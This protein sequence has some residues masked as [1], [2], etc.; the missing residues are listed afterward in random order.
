LAFCEFQDSGI[1]TRRALLF[2][3]IA[4]GE[5]KR[6]KGI[7]KGVATRR[8]IMIYGFGVAPKVIQERGVKRRRCIP[9]TPRKCLG[10]EWV[11][12]MQEER[13]GLM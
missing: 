6:D 4:L 2:E 13:E 9:P 12:K 8:M 3:E 1:A 10:K 7:S 5:A 11:E